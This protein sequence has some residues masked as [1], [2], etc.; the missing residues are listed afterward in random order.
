MIHSHRYKIKSNQK[1]LQKPTYLST[2]VPLLHNC[3]KHSVVLFLAM[4]P[5][6]LQS[7]TSQNYVNVYLWSIFIPHFTCVASTVHMLLPSNRTVCK[8]GMLLFYI[9]QKICHNKS[10]FLDDHFRIIYYINCK[11]C[12]F[13]HVSSCVPTIIINDL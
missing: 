9:P 7:N 10:I 8:D 12:H 1:W 3:E 4:K 6:L 5:L 13:H 11:Q 2:V